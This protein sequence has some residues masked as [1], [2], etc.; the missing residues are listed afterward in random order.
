[1]YSCLNPQKKY[2]ADVI[3][4]I[5]YTS[6]NEDGLNELHRLVI[7]ELNNI[8]DKFCKYND[9][10]PE[11]IYDIVLVGNT[12]MLH[13]AACIPCKQIAIFPFRPAFTSSIKVKA[14]DLGLKSN[15]ES[16]IITLP[17]VS[18]YIGADTMAAILAC[19]MHKDKKLAC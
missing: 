19:G 8:I 10:H 5:N 13:L 14:K 7:S 12:T 11:N 18:S 17:S 3:S 6:Q 9:I 4:R 15:P 2:G 1:M 16:Y